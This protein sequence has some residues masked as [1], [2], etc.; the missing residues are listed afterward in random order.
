MKNNHYHTARTTLTSNIT[1]LHCQNNHN[2]K[3]HNTTPSE[4]I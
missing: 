4:Q 1:I 2:V 3:H